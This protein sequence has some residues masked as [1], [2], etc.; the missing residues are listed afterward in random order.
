MD[1]SHKRTGSTATNSSG[2]NSVGGSPRK[3][4]LRNKIVGE[5][6]VLAGKIGK[7]EEKVAEGRRILQGEV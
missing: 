3:V 2:T 1:A 5:A 6:K 7:K 4:S